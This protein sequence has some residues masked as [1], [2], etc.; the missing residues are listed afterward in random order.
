[1]RVNLCARDPALK[2]QIAPPRTGPK[3]RSEDAMLLHRMS[4]VQG[5]NLPT[6]GFLQLMLGK[7]RNRTYHDV[8]LFPCLPH[9]IRGNPYEQNSASHSRSIGV[10]GFRSPPC[11][12]VS[13]VFRLFQTKPLSIHILSHCS[14]SPGF[15]ADAVALPVLLRR[16]NRATAPQRR[17]CYG[18][19]L[20]RGWPLGNA[21]EDFQNVR[22][23]CGRDLPGEWSEP[24]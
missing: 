20:P 24:Q 17:N 11:R 2:R 14:C 6:D 9:F 4:A 3:R 15:Q 1:M 12:R 21:L 13:N 16:K 8:C 10:E 22:R 7:E 5:C 19:R 23:P 18:N